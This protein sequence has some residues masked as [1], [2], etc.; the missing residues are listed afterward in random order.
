MK[1]DMLII[2]MLAFII[3]Y[4]LAQWLFPG[5]DKYAWEQEKEKSDSTIAALQ[6][7]YDSLQLLDNSL[8][9][10]L[11]ESMHGKDSVE[12]LYLRQ[13]SSVKKV[14]EKYVQIFNHL[15]SLPSDSH[16]VQLTTRLDSI[17]KR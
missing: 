11:S 14:R 1:K 16:Y 7:S 2:S 8:T 10:A 12:L 4:L 15:D 6:I 9:H 5:R 13:L 3:L 17:N